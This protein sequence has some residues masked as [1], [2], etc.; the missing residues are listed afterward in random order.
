MELPTAGALGKSWGSCQPWAR[1]SAPSPH[2]VTTNWWNLDF[3]HISLIP[4]SLVRASKEGGGKKIVRWYCL[5][6][7]TSGSWEPLKVPSAHTH[8]LSCVCRVLPL[9]SRLWCGAVEEGRFCMTLGKLLS[10]SVP[11][12]SCL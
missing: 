7:E 12:L 11:Q 10:L 2:S 5:A 4:T 6:I 8:Q 9:E 1:Q 3:L